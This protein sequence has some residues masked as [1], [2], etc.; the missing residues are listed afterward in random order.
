MPRNMSFMLTTDQIRNQTKTV[1]RRV[2]WEFLKPGDVLNACVKCQGIKKGEKIER[3]CE[4]RVKSAIREPLSNIMYEGF[5]GVEAEGFKG[6]RPREFVDMF[7]SEMDVDPSDLVTR[8]EFEYVE[9]A[10]A[11]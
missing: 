11:A 6:M 2:G 4:I 3:I 7:C 5:A 8:I 10:N 1:T 9:A